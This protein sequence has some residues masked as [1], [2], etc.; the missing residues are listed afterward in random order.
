MGVFCLGSK[1]QAFI[2]EMSWKYPVPSA[3]CCARATVETLGCSS[4]VQG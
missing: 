2:L 3:W 4:G 1:L